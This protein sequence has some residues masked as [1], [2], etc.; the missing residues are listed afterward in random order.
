MPCQARHIAQIAQGQPADGAGVYCSRFS[1]IAVDRESLGHPRGSCPTR[2]SRQRCG[3]THR[4]QCALDHP[5]WSRSEGTRWG[6]LA[7]RGRILAR[8]RSAESVSRS[9]EQV[10]R[11]DSTNFAQTLPTRALSGVSVPGNSGGGSSPRSEASRVKVLVTGLYRRILESCA[12]PSANAIRERY[13]FFG[14]DLGNVA[15]VAPHGQNRAS[16]PFGL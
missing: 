4:P 12:G 16:A 8:G 10:L 6:A 13:R 2:T 7:V 11:L 3:S 15:K 14:A 5:R 1:V 9:R